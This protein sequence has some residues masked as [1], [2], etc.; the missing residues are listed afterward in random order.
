[1]LVVSSIKDDSE[2][3]QWLWDE[4]VLFCFKDD[5]NNV[6]IEE[7]DCWIV[8][9]DGKDEDEVEECEDEDEDCEVSKVD[10]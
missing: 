3:V 5:D 4:M 1:M 7:D 10:D 9:I 6:E 2:E 8:E